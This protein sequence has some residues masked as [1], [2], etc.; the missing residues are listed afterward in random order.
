MAIVNASVNHRNGSY[1][2]KLQSGAII[3]SHHKYLMALLKKEN[4]QYI[5][6]YQ[7]GT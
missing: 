6:N 3:N 5:H 4:Q 7:C 1:I 2:K